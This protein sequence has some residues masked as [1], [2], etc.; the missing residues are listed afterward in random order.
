MVMERLSFLSYI[1][2]I[3]LIFISASTISL[4]Y[5]LM[6]AQPQII[7]QVVWTKGTLKAAL[8]SAAPRALARRSEIYQ[9]DTLTTDASSSGEIVFTDNSKLSVR[10]DSIIEIDQYRYS[11]GAA[12]DKDAFI[13]N[14]AKGGFRTITGAISKNN[15]GGYKATTP[16]ATIGVS[17]TNYSV[18][19]DPNKKTMAAKL[20]KGSIFISNQ[21]GTVQLKKC[22]TDQQ[23]KN[24]MNTVYAEVKGSDSAPTLLT[25]Q[26]TVFD[27]EPPLTNTAFPAA[28]AET[29]TPIGSFCI[30]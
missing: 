2:F 8:P 22:S 24:C 30:N 13:V 1:K 18:Y 23:G 7:G 5:A 27:V 15:P 28:A 12:K 17:G 6:P 3:F 25:E 20:N 19:F 9:H 11:K 10:E 16:V 14:V 21:Q 4:S 29:D 26:P